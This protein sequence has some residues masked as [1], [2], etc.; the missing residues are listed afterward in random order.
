MI[1][2]IHS[3]KT[4]LPPIGSGD[5]TL[6][7]PQL[8]SRSIEIDKYLKTLS[9][10][11]IGKIMSISKPLSLK[12]KNLIADWSAEPNKQCKAIDSFLGDIYSGL[13]AHDWTTENLEYANKTLR[14]LSGLYGIL[15][16]NDGIYPYRLEMGYKLPN[17]KFSSLYKYWGESI[18]NTLPNSIPIVNL[19]AVEYSKVVT[20]FVDS[21]I[22]TTPTFYTINPIT[23]MPTFVAVHSKIARGAFANW[24]I[25]NRITDVKDLAS[26]NDI[27]YKH[28]T[29]LSKSNFPAF[30]AKEFYGK[31]LSIRLQHKQ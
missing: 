15:R 31:G 7:Q 23:Q 13:Q 6:T 5:K 9:A 14:I 20:D 22:V 4:M 18:V 21:N 2:L 11:K 29:K 28:S 25:K 8:L 26:F 1:I 17:K 3:S 30:V 19:S 24:L 27:G 12:T 16:P 10:N